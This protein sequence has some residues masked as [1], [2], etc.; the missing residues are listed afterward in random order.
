[1]TPV[2]S[3]AGIRHAKTAA[4]VLAIAGTRVSAIER[5][6]W[7]TWTDMKLDAD[8]MERV[9]KAAERA[10]EW[11][12]R[13]A[14]ETKL[15]AERDRERWED[16]IKPLLGSLRELQDSDNRQG[17]VAAV[18]QVARKYGRPL[19]WQSFDEFDR[20]ARG[21]RVPAIDAS[22]GEGDGDERRR[23]I[24]RLGARKSAG[25]A[26]HDDGLV[27]ALTH[28]Y[29]DAGSESSRR[30]SHVRVNRGVYWHHGI[31]TGF[32]AVTH[33]NGEPH[34]IDD[35]VVR[36]DPWEFFRGSSREVQFVEPIE[37]DKSR[38]ARLRRDVTS[39]LAHYGRGEKGYALLCNNCEHFAVRAQLGAGF[40]IQARYPHLNLDQV[41][42]VRRKLVPD[43]PIGDVLAC[44]YQEAPRM[45]IRQ[46]LEDDQPTPLA[47]A[48]ADGM[49]SDVYV[50]MP[51]FVEGP[52][53]GVPP[54]GPDEPWSN[55]RCIDWFESP[56]VGSLEFD[57]AN[58][59]AVLLWTPED[60]FIWVTESG[61]YR[62]PEQDFK[63]VIDKR[64]AP[65]RRRLN[66]YFYPG[67]VG[68][69]MQRTGSALA[70]WVSKV[71][72]EP[73]DR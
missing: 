52:D 9:L 10:I 20:I 66:A 39:T 43:E 27:A 71:R 25:P 1:M 14:E 67:V 65:H 23:A 13:A 34:A 72:S 35:A 64:L 40:S 36:C 60:E 26:S 44:S 8:R 2:P 49:S 4:A 29:R 41:R 68:E 38:I 61:E 12:T 53:A 24:A 15:L 32:G 37:L 42:R 50:Y 47:Y 54:A 59:L 16:E 19:P 51:L 7:R 48:F 33:F 3:I 63:K 11:N 69:G 18:A 62:T 70:K 55:H 57:Y 30:G 5:L 21:E 58:P 46:A 6:V 45:E 73:G 17:Q 28:L 56:P 31:V 22:N